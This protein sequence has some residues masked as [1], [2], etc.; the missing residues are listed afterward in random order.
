MVISHAFHDIILGI[1]IQYSNA[2]WIQF[3]NDNFALIKYWYLNEKCNIVSLVEK[4]NI[5]VLVS[6][7]IS[8]YGYRKVGFE[9]WFKWIQMVPYLAH[10]KTQLTISRNLLWIGL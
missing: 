7:Y 4:P 6:K 8:C 3:I 9:A 10:N 1:H 2:N 5:K